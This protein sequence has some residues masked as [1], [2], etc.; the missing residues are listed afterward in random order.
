MCLRFN[1]SFF[2]SY[3]CF[4]IQIVGIKLLT[5]IVSHMTLAS[6]P[7]QVLNVDC[8]LFGGPVI[9]WQRLTRT[10]IVQPPNTEWNLKQSKGIGTLQYQRNSHFTSTINVMKW[11]NEYFK[12]MYDILHS[13]CYVSYFVLKFI[14]IK[15]SPVY[16]FSESTS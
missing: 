3:E 9:K 13:L 8:F 10:F 4:I 2:E 1:F 16:I 15:I 5:C 6:G 12:L 11:S 7:G 14:D